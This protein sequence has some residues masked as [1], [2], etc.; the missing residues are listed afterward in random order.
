MKYLSNV[1]EITVTF[2]W[3]VILL[4]LLFILFPP[5]S[6]GVKAYY[7][8]AALFL[9]FFISNTVLSFVSEASFVRRRLMS[10]P[11]R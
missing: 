1:K 3:L 7:G 9:L 10:R 5:Q 2:R 8:L 11:S 4:L 6:I